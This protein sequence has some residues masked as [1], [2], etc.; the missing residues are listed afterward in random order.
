MQTRTI[1]ISVGA[2]MMLGILAAAF[3]AIQV[4]GININDGRNETYKVSAHFN[5]VSG[6]AVRAQITIAGVMVGRVTAINLDPI[7]NRAKVE[8]AIQKNVDFITSD[9][10]AASVCIAAIQT[11]GVLGEKYI[12][13]SLGG[14]GD[15]L[16][17]GDEIVDTQSALILE[18]LISKMLVS[19]A[20]KKEE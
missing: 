13:I 1:E 11:E 7:D 18:D 16:K 9:S 4:S 6:L 20:G 17:E 14:S 10:I 19:L 15:I 5:N 12:S 8:M 3:L 2:F